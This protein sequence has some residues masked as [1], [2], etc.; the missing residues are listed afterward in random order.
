MYEVTGFNR[1]QQKTPLFILPEST[2][3][4]DFEHPYE[5]FLLYQFGFL[6][7]N[8]VNGIAETVIL[9]ILFEDSLLIGD[10]VALTL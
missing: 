9:R 4:F 1:L 10:A 6:H 3:F 5:F 2:L 7:V 8:V